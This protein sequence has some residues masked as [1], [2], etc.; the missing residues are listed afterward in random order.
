MKKE[1]LLPLRHSSSLRYT[2]IK[3]LRLILGSQCKDFRRRRNSPQ[4]KQRDGYLICFFFCARPDVMRHPL[5]FLS[6]PALL[7]R[8]SSLHLPSYPLN[9]STPF[10]RSLKAPPPA[11]PHQSPAREG[12]PHPHLTHPLKSLLK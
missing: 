6:D 10:L 5:C 11:S 8:S 9:P 3:L 4:S 12:K 2:L 1:C 7:V